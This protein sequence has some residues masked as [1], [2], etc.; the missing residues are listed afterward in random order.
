[1]RAGVGLAAFEVFL[2]GR[3]V[4]ENFG[5]V[6]SFFDSVHRSGLSTTH[7]SN[8]LVFE[9]DSISLEQLIVS[10]SAQVPP[11]IGLDA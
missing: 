1:V 4:L 6:V 10:I 3:L 5:I 7:G 9:S 2:T 11:I 8:G